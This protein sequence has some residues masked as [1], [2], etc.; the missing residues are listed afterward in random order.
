MKK[1]ARHKTLDEIRKQCQEHG[2]PL[3]TRLYDERGYDTVFVGIGP[4]SGFAI[5]NT[6]NGRF[7]GRTPDGVEFTSDEDTHDS[8]PWMQA[9]LNFF[10]VSVSPEPP[11]SHPAT[12]LSYMLGPN[13]PPNPKARSHEPTPSIF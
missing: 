11:A 3:N 2:V 10:M 4:D 13:F 8:E 6:F 7:F 5:Y 9:L 1:F 12:T